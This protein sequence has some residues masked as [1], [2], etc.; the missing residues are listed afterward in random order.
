MT[1]AASISVNVPNGIAQVSEFIIGDEVRVCMTRRSIISGKISSMVL[2]TSLGKVTRYS[3]EYQ[4]H[5]IQDFFPELDAD[6]REFILSGIKA[7][8][9]DQMSGGEDD[10]V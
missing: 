3:N 4:Q 2:N 8:E 1:I 10:E 6:E 9:W 5:Y 7:S